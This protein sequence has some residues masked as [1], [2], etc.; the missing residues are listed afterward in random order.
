MHEPDRRGFYEVHREERLALW[1]K[2]YDEPGFGI[3][4]ANFRE[5]FMDEEAN[6]EF[7]EYIADQ[8]RRRVK[9][10]GDRR[11]ADPARTTASACSGCRWR[12]T[13]T[14]PTTAQRAAGRHQRDADRAHHRN[15]H[16]HDRARLRVRHHRL[17]H[18][19]RRHHRRLRPH[20]HPRRRRPEA[21]AT[22]GGRPVDL[23]RHDGPRLPEHADAG[24]PAERLGLDQLSRA[25]SS[26][27][28]TGAPT[29]C[30]TCG[31]HGYTRFEATAEAE[32]RWTA[33]VA[34]A[35]TP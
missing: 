10:P 7:S 34:Q 3:W 14:R 26:P 13:T 16:P 32:E 24:R 2:L 11:E 15:R 6:A 33:H 18:R 20:R 25:A 35:C 8:I 27:A 12:P 1:E 17:R 22:S 21:R 30:S 9:D 28:S 5:I 31:Q 19:L 29:C 23:P 4:L